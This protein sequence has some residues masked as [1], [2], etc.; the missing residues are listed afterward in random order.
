MGLFNRIIRKFVKFFTSLQEE[1]VGRS[2]PL[3]PAVTM[4]TEPVEESVDE[5]LSTA[6]KDLAKKQ[7][8]TNKELEELDLSQ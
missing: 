3:V 6:A 4:D 5:E 8:E 2:L 7:V 1:D